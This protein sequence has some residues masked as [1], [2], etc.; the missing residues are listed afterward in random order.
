MNKKEYKQAAAADE[1]MMVGEP[2]VGY[3]HSSESLKSRILATINK[4]DDTKVLGECLSILL[5]SVGT[6]DKSDNHNWAAQY[7]GMWNDDPRSTEEIIDDIYG[8]RS[9]NRENIEL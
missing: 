5:C 2:A 1:A 8:S 7:A 6:S 4:V 9:I 3:V